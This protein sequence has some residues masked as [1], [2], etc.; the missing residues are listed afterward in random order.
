MLSGVAF[1][2][3]ADRMPALSMGAMTECAT[4]MQPESRLQTEKTMTREGTRARQS[5]GSLFIEVGRP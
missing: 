2:S 5:M 1:A 3:A 4:V